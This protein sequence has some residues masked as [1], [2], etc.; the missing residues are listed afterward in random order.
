MAAD[1]D[2]AADHAFAG[3]REEGPFRI[4]TQNANGLI[5]VRGG[6]PASFGNAGTGGIQESV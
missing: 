5:P 4:D 1:G 2:R 6:E 3:E